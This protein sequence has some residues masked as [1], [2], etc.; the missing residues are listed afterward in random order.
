MHAAARAEEPDHASDVLEDIRKAISADDDD[1][2]EARSRLTLV[3]GAAETFEGALRTF[4]SGS[5]AH[6]TV[7]NPVTDG[8]GGVVLDRRSYPSLGPDSD[9]EGGP[10]D[11]VGRMRTHVMKAVREEYPDAK[12]RLTKRAILIRFNEPLEEPVDG[13]DPVDPTVDLVV[14]LTRKDEVGIWIPNRDSGAWDASD[15]ECHTKL[16][17]AKPEAVRRLRSR[18]IRLAKSA[19]KQDGT[20]VMI[21]FHIE[22]LALK[23]ITRDEALIVALERFFADAAKKLRGGDTD[24]PAGVSGPIKLPK[25]IDRGRAAKRLDFFAARV[26]AAIDANDRTAAE[27]E[28]AQVFPAQLPDVDTSD[29]S[30][31][32]K[33]IREGDTAKLS[34]VF[35]V[36]AA[37]AI[38]AGRSFGGDD[39]AAA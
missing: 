1:L 12:S 23:S 31:T 5:L 19:V 2:R 6:R 35:G 14:G 34:R 17:T 8:D 20:P 37:T 16:L 4:R 27:K 32:A 38:P 28:L 7:N 30:K 25:G 15:P 29:K 39:G 21:S 24:D 26:K 11:I 9:D 33:A 36:P 18:V 3:L 13:E 22:A 10:E